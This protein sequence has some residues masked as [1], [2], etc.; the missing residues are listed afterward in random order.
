MGLAR[1][2]IVNISTPSSL[3]SVEVSTDLERKNSA[4]QVN[5][6][7]ARGAKP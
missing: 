5:E 6:S 3:E 4:C 7:K 1:G 2:R